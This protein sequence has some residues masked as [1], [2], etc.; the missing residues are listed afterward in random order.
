MMSRR[1]DIGTD[2][3]RVRV[4]PPR[5][6]RPRTKRRPAHADAL[7]AQVVAV[8][9]GRYQLV[10]DDGRRIIGMKARELGRG[11]RNPVVVGDVVNVVG[12]TSGR[13]GTLARI[14]GVQE[15]DTALRRSAEDSEAA[16]VERVIVANAELMIIVAAL[17]DPPPRPRLVDR[18]LVAAYDAGMQVL[19]VLTKADLADPSEFLAGY[20][21]LDLPVVVTAQPPGG[22][23]VEGLDELRDHIGGR[24]AVMVGHSGVGKSTLINALVPAASQATAQ[25][26]VVTG[27]GRHTSSA[28]IAFDLPDGGWI[29]DTP[30]VRSFGLSHVSPEGV[31]DAF[32]DLR[33]V[34]QDCPRGCQHTAA[35]P[36]CALDTWV[37]SG[38]AG[39]SGTARVES[40]RRLLDSRATAPPQ[41]EG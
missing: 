20:A 22:E 31:L 2:D 40:F 35:D 16:G 25:V 9:R 4:R 21:A 29:I 18:C 34:V 10:L 7:P 36:D 24:R 17:A 8:D 39:P 41:R 1:R 30:G 12:D 32:T 26:N 38:Q 6:T 15:R 11:V 28:A 19:L 13:E 14:V 27:R 33:E 23:E 5:G 3:E 37:A